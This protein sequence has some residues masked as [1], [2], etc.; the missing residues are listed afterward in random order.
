MRFF[1]SLCLFLSHQS[2]SQ[3]LQ[4]SFRDPISIAKTGWIEHID[5]GHINNDNYLDVIYTTYE[6]P[7]FYY[8]LGT[9]DKKFGKIH[10]TPLITGNILPNYFPVELFD[11]NNDGKDEVITYSNSGYLTIFRYGA[12]G[13]EEPTYILLNVSNNVQQIKA[14]DLD[15][16]GSVEI[17]LTYLNL[18]FI[19]ILSKE[20]NGFVHQNINTN[21]GYSGQIEVEDFNQDQKLDIL[22]SDLVNNNLKIFEGGNNLN[23]TLSKTLNFENPIVGYSVADVSGDGFNDI[24]AIQN[25]SYNVKIL[26]NVGAYNFSEIDIPVDQYNTLSKGIAIGDINEDGRKDLLLGNQNTLIILENKSN[27]VFT[28]NFYPLGSSLATQSISHQDVNNDGIEEILVGGSIIGVYSFKNDE[29]VLD[30]RIPISSNSVAGKL[31]DLNQDGILDVVSAGTNSGFLEIYYGIDNLKFSDPVFLYAGVQPSSIDLGDFNNDT[32]PDILFSTNGSAPPQRIGIFLSNSTD[33]TFNLNVIKEAY[34]SKTIADDFD[35]DGHLDFFAVNQIFY[36]NGDGTFIPNIFAQGNYIYQYD[37]GYFNN[38]NQLDIVEFK[39]PTEI[40]V[41][42][43]TSQRSYANPIVITSTNIPEFYLYTINAFDF[44]KDDLTDFIVTAGSSLSY[45]T[46]NGDGTF[47]ESSSDLDNELSTIISLKSGDFNRDGLIDFAAG[48]R[49]QKFYTFLGNGIAFNSGKLFPSQKNDSFNDLQVIDLN[50]DSVDDI[51]SFSVYRPYVINFYIN[52]TAFEPSTTASALQFTSKTNEAFSL[53][54]QPGNGTERLVIVSTAEILSTL[55]KDG[56][57]YTHNKNFGVGSSLGVGAYAVYRGSS[58]SIEVKGLTKNTTYYV[59][60]FEYNTN[61]A[62][63]QINYLSS[64]YATASVRTKDTQ[65]IVVPAIESISLATT[66]FDINAT[67]SSSLPVS[68]EIIKGGVTVEGL[69]IIPTIPGPVELKFTQNGNNDYMPAAPVVRSFCINPL[70][71]TFTVTEIEDGYLLT[72][73]SSIN[74]QWLRNNEQIP[75]ETS[76]T[77]IVTE[78]DIYSLKVNYDN[79]FTISDPLELIVTSLTI[80]TS[81][82]VWPNPVETFLHLDYIEQP[83]QLSLI[84][85][86]GRITKLTSSNNV[87]DFRFISKGHYIL[88]LEF[89]NSKQ[90]FRIVKH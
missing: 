85:T 23:F 68:A 15:K 14:A 89:K 82:E 75:N 84:D 60:V 72:S 5:Y 29:P 40:L 7:N 41:H 63:T 28:K 56:T 42:L 70:K 78:N 66:S 73:S 69:R 49:N 47:S 74:N 13:F 33:S 22:I 8:A 65:T 55:P 77:L 39:S 18:G 2:Y 52:D 50:N 62:Q 17:I 76:Q 35:A 53:N 26:T 58:P 59:S 45:F 19:Q 83:L 67:A 79:C 81:L 16:N 25:N 32:K 64:N 3:L 87:I 9:S 27:N 71:P 90:Y 80:E 24:V 46:N 36:G 61:L 1:F 38:D 30:F 11:T 37:V 34:T 31:A 43:S 86:E 12:I 21:L 6:D 20:G 48:T 4:P 51:V 57:F 44:T 88:V 54:Y 10:K